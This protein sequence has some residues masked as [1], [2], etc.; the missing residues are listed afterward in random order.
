MP[1]KTSYVHKAAKANGRYG[2]LDYFY[3][4]KTAPKLYELGL[5]AGQQWLLD[6]PARRNCRK[7]LA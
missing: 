5:G 6:S 3:A 7:E 4:G 1:F 2:V